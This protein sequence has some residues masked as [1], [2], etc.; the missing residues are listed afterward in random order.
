LVECTQALHRGSEERFETFEI[1]IGLRQLTPCVTEDILHWNLG[2][3]L[4]HVERERRGIFASRQTD[5]MAYS[6]ISKGS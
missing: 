4:L 2:I 1:V 6:R 5:N 3:A